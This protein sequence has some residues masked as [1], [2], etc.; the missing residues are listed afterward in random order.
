MNSLLSVNTLVAGYTRPITPALS[1]EIQPGEVVGLLGANGCG[2]STVLRAIMGTA[3]IFSGTL[4]KRP[5]LRLTHQR[6]SPVRLKQMPIRG[7]ELLRVCER[8]Q[9]PLPAKLQAVMNQ[10]LDQLSGGQLQLLQT[11]ACFGDEVDLILLDEPT[12]NLDPEGIKA[13]TDA[14]NHLNAHQAVLMVSHEPEFTA[15]VC[16]QIVTMNHAG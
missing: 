8:N 10:R 6:Q 7:W 5:R 1:F 16:T 11:W 3:R 2:K 14:F 12:N 4:Y 13:L 15:Q 9:K